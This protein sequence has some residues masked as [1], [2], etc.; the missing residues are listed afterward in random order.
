MSDTEYE[1]AA[2][3]ETD[4]P[5]VEVDET[6]ERRIGA[7]LGGLGVDVLDHGAV[8]ARAEE[9]LPDLVARYGNSFE[10]AIKALDAAVDDLA[11]TPGKD[12]DTI[13]SRHVAR[14]ERA[15]KAQS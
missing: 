10:T 6:G 9:L 11:V 12:H 7:H 5:E 2:E 15:E 13:I 1:A 8:K 14:L 3:V 4:L